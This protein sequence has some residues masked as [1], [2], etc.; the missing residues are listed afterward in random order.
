[1]NDS[2]NRRALDAV[3]TETQSSAPRWIQ[4]LVSTVVAGLVV[5]SV[6]GSFTL[7]GT[8]SGMASDIEHMK[9]QLSSVDEFHEEPRFIKEQ[10]VEMLFP[11]EIQINNL[12]D[13]VT[14]LEKRADWCGK[15]LYEVKENIIRLPQS[16]A[17][18]FDKDWRDQITQ[19]TQDIAICGCQGPVRRK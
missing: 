19:N 14:K 13:L 5:A 8:V 7:R 1:M 12:G 16:L 6:I 10:A 2:E 9:E 18:P 15:T 4:V 11:L 3:N 17:F